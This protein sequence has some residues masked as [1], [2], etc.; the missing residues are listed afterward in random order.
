V[1]VL[2]TANPGIDPGLLSIGT[3]LIIPLDEDLLVIPSPTPVNVVLEEPYCSRTAGGGMWCF[4]LLRNEQPRALENPSAEIVLYDGQG[5][6]V[7]REMAEAPLNLVPPGQALPLTVYFPPNVPDEV[8]S[9]AQLQRTF[10]QPQ[11]DARYL[12]VELLTGRV[13]IAGDGASASVEGEVVRSEGDGEEPAETQVWVALVA[14]GTAGQVVGVRRWEWRGPLS[15]GE[16][17]AFQAQVF[18]LG[19][20]ISEVQTFAEALKIE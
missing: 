14:Y 5:V 15:A 8:L 12:L 7:A 6:E 20:A 2:Q 19:P 4:L 10:L 1:D 11:E 18:S 16:G 9:L 17:V 13:E 3:E